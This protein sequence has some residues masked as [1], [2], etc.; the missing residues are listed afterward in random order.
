MAKIIATEGYREAGYE[1]INIDDCWP[2]HKRAPDGQLQSDPD[3]F[4]NGMK[5]LADYVRGM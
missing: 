5:A 4:P 3:R 1:Y 2:A